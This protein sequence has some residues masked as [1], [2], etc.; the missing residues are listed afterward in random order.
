MS[1][2]V[3]RLG[4]NCTHGAVIITASPDRVVNGSPVA[5]LGD[6]VNCP[7]EGHGIN[8]I[9]NV[10][11]LPTTDGQQTAHVFAQAAC[12]ALIITGSPNTTTG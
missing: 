12:G 3:A 7:Q 9:I 8:P 1:F 5:R 2:P 4:D 11:A 10:M 6:L